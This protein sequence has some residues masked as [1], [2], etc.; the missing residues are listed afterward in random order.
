M[1]SNR[2]ELFYIVWYEVILNHDTFPL[3][4]VSELCSSF[5]N[6]ISS[7]LWYSDTTVT[8]N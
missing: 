7:E 6:I 2:C 1:L 5:S 4:Q 3:L 8:A